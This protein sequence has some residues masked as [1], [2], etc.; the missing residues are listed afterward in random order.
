MGFVTPESQW[1]LHDG[2]SLKKQIIQKQNM[3]ILKSFVLGV[4]VVAQWF[5]NLTRIHEDVGSIP[6]LPQWV[7]DLVWWWAVV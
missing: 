7:K 5:K 1:E 6:G 3:H 4:A 2:H